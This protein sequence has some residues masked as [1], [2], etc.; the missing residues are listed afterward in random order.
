[1]TDL[2]R[3]LT[4]LFASGAL[5]GL[6][7]SLC[8]WIFGIAGITRA[9]GVAIAPGLTPLWLYPRLV[10]GGIWGILFL[11]P[12]FRRRPIIRGILMSL[13]PSFVQLAIV[14]P[15][16]T[17]AGMLGLELGLLTPLFVIFFN[18]IWGVATAYWLK[19]IE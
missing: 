7:N 14:F 2:S 18:A 13:G 15:Q 12:L 8:V 3:R 16:K 9:L 6:A 4:L 17:G 5:G 11:L 19:F 10:W 1:M